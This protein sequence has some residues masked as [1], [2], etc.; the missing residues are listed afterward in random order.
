M[1]APCT[2]DSAAGR[3]DV[4]EQFERGAIDP[5]SF[6]HAAHVHVAWHF[7]AALGPEAGTERFVRSLKALTQKLGMPMKYHETVTRFFL[8]TIVNRR[9]AGESWED[10]ALRNDDLLESGSALLLRYYSPALLSDGCARTTFLPPDRQP[11]AS[12]ELK[13]VLDAVDRAC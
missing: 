6:D 13:R 7:I 5:D 12:A 4:I 3:P 8:R 1:S 10:F 11:E 2:A 9:V